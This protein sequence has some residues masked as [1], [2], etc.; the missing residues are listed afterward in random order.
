MSDLNIKIS[1][2]SK[3]DEMY[4]KGFTHGFVVSLIL[5]ALLVITSF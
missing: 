5:I 3:Y 4:S 2:K 1:P